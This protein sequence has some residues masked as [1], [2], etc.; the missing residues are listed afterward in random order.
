MMM[1]LPIAIVMS[2]TTTL[3]QRIKSIVSNTYFDSFIG[4]IILLNSILLA[5]IDYQVVDNNYQPSITSPRNNVIEKCEI[6][7]TAIFTIE[8]IF[9]VVAYGFAKGK[10]A[11]IRDGWNVLDFVILAISL[12]GFV[13]GIPN[14]S[15]LRSFRVLRPLRS[16]SKLPNVRKIASAFIDSIGDLA[17]VGVLLLFIIVF[18]ALFGVTFWRGL[19]HKRCR[20]TPFPV[21]MPVGCRNAT[22]SC[23]DDFLL[24]VVSNPDEYRCLP[25]P[26]DDMNNSWTQSTSPWFEPQDCVWPIDE[27]DLRVCSSV[28]TGSYTCS[29]PV[30][31]MGLEGVSRTCGR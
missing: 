19:F 26:N 29:K 22:E 2:P 16:V 20:L 9:K 12:L 3:R 8:C 5:C 10:R 4:A 23:W 1:K 28:G 14:L 21:K 15:M 31:V 17:N 30:N 27:T 25:F 24:D 6:I 11:Y 7:F 18:F 13:P